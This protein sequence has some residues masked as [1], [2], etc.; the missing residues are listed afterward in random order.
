MIKL[1]IVFSI[2]ILSLLAGCD[3]SSDQK[4]AQDQAAKVALADQQKQ[5][6][7]ENAH[8]AF[9]NSGGKSFGD[10]YDT[11]NVV[12]L[13]SC[14]DDLVSMF[15][16]YRLSL[17][18]NRDLYADYTRNSANSGSDCALGGVISLI[19]LATGDHSGPTPCKDTF[20]RHMQL[21]SERRSTF[22]TLVSLNK[23]LTQV[24]ARYKI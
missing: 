15:S 19:E 12:N 22:D 10:A 21:S 14:P 11:L 17:G 13:E 3:Q 1:N 6:C 7:I 4:A 18:T 5:L 23:E 20:V 9:I 16:S 24:F 8:T 2:A